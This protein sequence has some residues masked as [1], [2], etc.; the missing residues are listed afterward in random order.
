MAKD[1]LDLPDIF[2]HDILRKSYLK[3]CLKYHPDKNPKGAIMFQNVKNA[4]DF[5]TKYQNCNQ[6][7]DYNH[8]KYEFNYINL[9]KTFIATLFNNNNSNTNLDF[10]SINNIIQE[11]TTSIFENKKDISLKLIDK[12]DEETS[13]YIQK[14]LNRYKSLLNIP[15][16]FL[17][18]LRDHIHNKYDNLSII[19]LRPKLDDVFK[20]EIF[21]Y[22]E[23]NIKYYIPLW[24]HEMIF[25][26]H[27]VY[28]DIDLPDNV[29]IDINNNIYI[30][31]HLDVSD[32][33]HNTNININIGEKIVM[34]KRS[35]IKFVEFQKIELPYIGIPRINEEI[36][37]DNVYKSSIIVNLYINL[38]I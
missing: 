23:Q 29:T 8:N 35:D 22:T 34:I 21:V 14:I 7:Y 27:I 31:K 15:N 30:E 24:H 3:K 12:L 6:N 26:S 37:Y 32:I 10:S 1:I 20:N 13:K 36:I 18:S 11:L 38:N 16:D 2:T 33:L 25:K 5:M 28:I 4:Y 17:D 9:F 19:T